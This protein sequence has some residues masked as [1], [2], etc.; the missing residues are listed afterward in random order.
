MQPLCHFQKVFAFGIGVRYAFDVAV[1]LFLACFCHFGRGGKAFEEF[2]CNHIDSFIGA[3]CREYH[4]N[5]QLK[6]IVVMQFR[7]SIGEK[8]VELLYGKGIAFFLSHF[9][10]SVSKSTIIGLWSEYRYLPTQ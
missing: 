3:L 8:S 4:G 10:F 5:E 6:R 1:Y 2:R 9:F 7:L